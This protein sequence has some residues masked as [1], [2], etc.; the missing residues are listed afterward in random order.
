M[1]ETEALGENYKRAFGKRIGFGKKPALILIDFVEAYFDKDCA[2]YAGVEDALASALR[3]QKV[4]RETNMPVIYTNVVYRPGGAD[5]GRFYQKSMV[6]HNFVQGSPM[7]NW[8]K[9]LEVAAD[10]LVI[11]KQYPSAFFGTSLASTLTAMG[12]DTLIHTGLSTSGCVR[13]T[14]VDSCSHGFI[15]IIVRDACGDRH[16]APHE[17]NLFDMDAKY[18]DVVS[19]AEAITYMQSL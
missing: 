13:A 14:C 17:S 9:G 12:I 7:G 8:P 15:P 5:G 6:L 11:S 2:L 1:A 16:E 4:A 10:E 18:G 19:E 3:L